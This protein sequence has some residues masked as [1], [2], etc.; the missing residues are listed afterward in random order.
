MNGGGLHVPVEKSPDAA[1]EPERSLAGALARETHLLEE[2]AATLER[3]REH[4]ANNTPQA[5]EHN[6]MAISRILLSLEEARSGR[7]ALTA[8]SGLDLATADDDALPPPVRR[9]REGLRAAARRVVEQLAINQRLL[10]QTLAAGDAYLQ[11]LFSWA[12]GNGVSYPAGPDAAPTT[13]FLDRT[14]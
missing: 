14:I 7:L 1:S 13:L 12:A 10:R 5:L 2:L 8:A 9:A 11:Q 3:Q 6:V 4:I